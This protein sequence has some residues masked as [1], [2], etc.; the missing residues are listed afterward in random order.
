MSQIGD[1][2]GPYLVTL[3]HHRRAPDMSSYVGW[4]VKDDTAD[5]EP[6]QRKERRS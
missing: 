6:L 2:L 1:L 3:A 5:A 4:R